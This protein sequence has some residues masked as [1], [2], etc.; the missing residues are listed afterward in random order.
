MDSRTQLAE[1]SLTAQ[2]ITVS[3]RCAAGQQ[4]DRSGPLAA[5]QLTAMGLV[6]YPVIVL[7]DDRLRIAQTVLR[8]CDFEPLS[9]LLFTGGTGPA[10]SDLTPTAIIPLLDRRYESIESAIHADGRH[11]TAKSPLSRVVVGARDKTVIVAVPGSPGGVQDTLTT[12]QPLL[13][14]LLALAQGRHD[15]H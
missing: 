1:I 14:H 5:F 2:V 3:D 13:P 11:S 7:P 12:L 15:P 9:L 8:F 4:E 6:V 10:P